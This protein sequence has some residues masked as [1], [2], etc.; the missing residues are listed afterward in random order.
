MNKPSD[1]L[2][3]V[4]IEGTLRLQFNK[5]FTFDDAIKYVD[6]FA[7]LGITHL[8]SS[9]ILAARHDS[10]HGYDIVDPTQI[11]AQ[12]GG[13]DGL[14]RLVTALRAAGMGLI[15][16]IVPNHLGVGGDENP[17][18]QH[19]FE[20][21]SA[22]P[23]AFWFDIDW[24][25]PD[26]QLHDKIL[27]PFLGEPYGEVLDKGDLAL[28]FDPGEGR[29]FLKYFSHRFPIA[30]PGYA[31]ILRH[32]QAPE[33]GAVMN[34]WNDLDINQPFSVVEKG[35]QNVSSALQEVAK[36]K[37]GSRA[38]E[39]CLDFYNAPTPESRQALHEL[40]ENQHY[41]LTWW[42]NAADEINWRRF[43][44]VSELAGIRVEL[45]E[46]FEAMHCQV[47]RLF[48]QGLIDGLRLD[49]IDGLAQPK[50]YCLK[51]RA[52][53][54]A[55]IAKR[56]PS[57]QQQPY[58]IAEK[59]L[60]ADEMLRADWHLDGTTGYEFMDQV[61]AVLHDPRGSE[62]LTALWKDLAKDPY[63]F[64]Q[65][66]ENSRRQLLS[67][68]LVGELS[69]TA[70]ALHR[71][72][73]ADVHTRDYSLAAIKRVLIEILVHFPVYRTYI[74]SQGPGE[75]DMEVLEATWNKAKR[76][77]SAVDKPL[78]DI[79]LGWLSAEWILKMPESEVA[80]LSKCAMTRF[81]QLTPPLLAKSVEDTSFY[82][83]GRLLSRNE[84]GSD[85]AVL[86]IAVEEFH[87]RCIARQA[88]YPRN[89][90]AT[91]THDHKRGEDARARIA[92][93]SQ[94]PQRWSEAVAQ[95]LQMNAR[96]HRDIHP[97][98]NANVTYNAPRAHHELMLYQTMIGSWPY[99]LALDDAAGLKAFA[100]RLDAWL[101]KSIREA[102][103]IS[104]WVQAN[105][106]YE[107]ACSDFVYKIMDAEQSP[108]FLQSLYAFIQE[109]SGT[110]AVN[111]LAQTLLRNTT[112]GIPDLYQGGELWDLS[113]VDPDNRTPVDYDMRR[114]LLEADPALND[115]LLNW[116][117]GT[118]K[119]HVI[120]RA[121]RLRK[122][123]RS[124]FYRGD[125]VPLEV[126]GA[127]AV[128]ILAF[129]RIEADKIAIVLAPRLTHAYTQT[130]EILSFTPDIW[131]DTTIRLPNTINGEMLNVLTERKY[132][133][134]SGRLEVS[135][136]LK[137]FP[138]ALLF[139]QGVVV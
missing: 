125:Y 1:N 15:I 102:K 33:L 93:L 55:L 79:V 68:N 59:I 103:R 23:Y 136:I 29:F 106:C 80:K 26:P 14:R 138:V 95:W 78:L 134:Y 45:D 12:L 49:H 81:Q 99:E 63:D 117:N 133:I 56:P 17:W 30:L 62:P 115:K 116:R 19:I 39:K 16:D 75:K 110:G 112:P 10:S 9:P 87:R 105:E 21:G 109:I 43:F 97:S 18:W 66:V 61:S 3:I 46:V 2:P 5:D 123:H 113:M 130:T 27:A 114:Q 122:E 31:E 64:P 52:R 101:L 84:V 86:S 58:L 54:E 72:A 7:A 6:Y 131:Q 36:N 37:N 25:S 41:R 73:R 34:T 96:F 76:T 24:Q 70:A 67:E 71:I 92:V 89:L 51:L 91:A 4:D 121:L 137:D 98:D 60:A 13:E 100:E 107:K 85:P 69:T 111:S 120:Q 11:N 139:M 127:K 77:L 83:Y 124:L 129:M 94:I 108:D 57:L 118:L 47:F 42:R 50:A 28:N 44:E 48:E 132:H 126:T 88:S 74:E 135:A 40:L 22:S 128:H 53:L 119:Q 32:A 82:R 38:L 104:N 35:A 65:H 90:L 20:W 8:Y